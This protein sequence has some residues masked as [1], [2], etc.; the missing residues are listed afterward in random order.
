MSET[1]QAALRRAEETVEGDTEIQGFSLREQASHGC[2]L[3]PAL[4]D[5]GT[6]LC[7]SSCQQ[8]VLLAKWIVDEGG[9]HKGESLP[10]IGT[11]RVPEAGLW[12]SGLSFSSSGHPPSL[13]CLLMSQYLSF[14]ICSDL[15][16]WEVEEI[17]V[18]M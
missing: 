11:Q 9:P 18:V 5:E 8:R 12:E 10:S 7:H 15:G 17:G 16:W 6:R 13:S 4:W 2:L 14:L 3:H 1:H